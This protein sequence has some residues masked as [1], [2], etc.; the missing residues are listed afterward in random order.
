MVCSLIQSTNH[1]RRGKRE[2]FVHFQPNIS[3]LPM[4]VHEKDVHKNIL[5]FLTMN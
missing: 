4:I 2:L 5:R 3:I 1:L